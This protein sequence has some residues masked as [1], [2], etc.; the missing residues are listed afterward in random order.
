LSG[1]FDDLFE[2]AIIDADGERVHSRFAPS[3][4]KRILA[5]P[6]SVALS[7]A[8]APGKSRSSVY[9]AEGSVAH[10]VAEFY[11]LGGSIPITHAPGKVIV[12]DGHDVVVTEE[13]HAYGKNYA[14]YVRDHMIGGD[15]LYV[16]QTVRMDAIV[17][18]TA[19][20]YGHLDAAIW[21]PSRR[22]L[23]IVDYK[24]GKGV[25]V[26]ALDNPQLKAYALGA[27]FTLP[28]V[29]PDE[30]RS[31]EMH[32]FQPRV[33]GEKPADTVHVLD[34]LNW[35]HGELASVTSLIEKDGAIQT[36]YVSGDHCR[37]CP[38]KAQC[39]ALRERALE[40]AKKAFE[41]KPLPPSALSDDELADALDEA[42]VVDVWVEAVREEGRA[43]A[44]AG[45]N[46]RGRKLVESRGRRVWIDEEAVGAWLATHGYTPDA[47]LTQRELMSVPQAE[48]V[49]AQFP[50]DRE[51][52][53][54]LWTT[55]SSG[56]SLVK[57][58]DARPGARVRPAH[59]VFK[60]APLPT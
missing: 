13:M 6:R 25:K 38:A 4:L 36:P 19:Q 48:K 31:V 57:S 27:M 46:I 47:F 44:E 30:V 59:E 60:D 14:R 41:D 39:P 11:L 53:N 7:E 8:V 28:D 3:A 29:D 51:S 5:C 18:E 15:F 49:V 24:Y 52:F 50:D 17:G 16:E 37:W 58:S 20:M 40:A 32:V 42:D 26:S 56:T 2:D 43:R 10:T 9:A 23:I 55:K 33:P 12:H 1:L 35:G 54:K 45:K 21:S 34:L 22:K